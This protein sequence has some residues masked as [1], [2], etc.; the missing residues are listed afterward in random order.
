MGTR[1]RT[2][3]LL[4]LLAGIGIW[5]AGA[6]WISWYLGGS[7]EAAGPAACVVS[8]LYL[9]VLF[10]VMGIGMFARVRMLLTLEMLYGVGV[11]FRAVIGVLTALLFIERP[12][13]ER[14]GRLFDALVR[15]LGG[16]EYVASR[17]TSHFVTEIYWMGLGLI[18]MIL[19]FLACAAFMS[20]GNRIARERERERRRRRTA[21]AQR[22]GES[23]IQAGRK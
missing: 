1:S 20:V 16:L 3:W 17:L 15:P 11:L 8:C 19:T 14:W 5:L 18:A 2:E 13:G 6:F 10:L 22:A 4:W 23:R 9:G 21:A 7:S 12:V